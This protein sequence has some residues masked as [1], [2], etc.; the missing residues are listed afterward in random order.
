MFYFYCAI[1]VY[2]LGLRTCL[3]M[4]EICILNIILINNC[5]ISLMLI[6][7]LH[8]PIIYKYIYIFVMIPY[9]FTMFVCTYEWV[10]LKNKVFYKCWL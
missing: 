7:Y 3:H 5:N 8:S 4:L 6:S 2:V 9:T 10:S 1:M